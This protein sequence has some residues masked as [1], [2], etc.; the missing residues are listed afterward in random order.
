MLKRKLILYFF[1]A[2]FPAALMAQV[3]DTL[4][5][6]QIISER[7]RQFNTGQKS[8][9]IDSITLQ[10]TGNNLLPDLLQDGSPVFVKN[11][12]PGNI[13]T[14]SFRGTNA[15]HTAV[16]WNG[17]NLQSPMLGLVDLSIISAGIA[18]EIEIRFGGNGALYGS[19]VIGG[20]IHL[21]SGPRF[22]SG[23]HASLGFSLGSFGN[24][25]Q[26]LRVEYGGTKSFTRLHAFNQTIEN[27][28]PFRNPYLA[29]NPEQNQIHALT[30]Q[31]SFLA[32]QY[33]QPAS[34]HV[35][36]LRY[37]YVHAMRE[38]PPT[39]SVPSSNATQ[40]DRSIRTSAEWKWHRK[41][42]TWMMRSAL[43][44]ADLNYIDLP[45]Q[46]QSISKV[47]TSISEIEYVRYLTSKWILSLGLNQ[48]YNTTKTSIYSF[49][50]NFRFAQFASLRWTNRKVSLTSVF[51]IRTERMDDRWIPVQPSWGWNWNITPT[52]R[53][54]SSLSRSYRVPTFNERYWV[55]GGNRS[56]QPE[57]GWGQ[58]L[59][60]AYRKQYVSFKWEAVATAFNRQIEGWIAWT[61]DSQAIWS[62]LNID[63]V[64]NRGVEASVEAT[65]VLGLSLTLKTVAGTNFIRSTFSDQT[66]LPYIPRNT[67]FYTLVL[68]NTYAYLRFNHSYTGMRFITN[69]N[70]QAL[71]DYMLGNIKTGVCIPLWKRACE[72]TFTCNNIFGTVYTVMPDRPMPL[73]NYAVGITIKL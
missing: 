58:E 52:V 18:D 63:R 23:T 5:E 43:F 41:R 60:A 14:P 13:A 42:H 53:L 68:S 72:L 37:W 24:Y 49:K 62:P 39:L 25:S 45:K 15:E 54:F 11:Y 48:T 17:F 7:F 3:S 38:V 33:F 55:P 21:N 46:I 34:N 51:S 16:L 26:Q 20:A 4:Q 36:N 44:A 35:L 73:R 50:E 27:N 22:G 40:E 56:L 29:G 6:V 69:D 67:Q 31:Q 8:T 30:R 70:L 9:L 59:S 65:F 64:W 28:F 47:Y 2:G 61:P 1:L 12:G 57:S 10:S 32:E 19:G 66:Q 71:D